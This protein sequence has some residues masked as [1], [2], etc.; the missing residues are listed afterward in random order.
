MVADKAT[1]SKPLPSRAAKSKHSLIRVGSSKTSPKFATPQKKRAKIVRFTTDDFTWQCWQCLSAFSN[2]V[3]LVEH[4]KS[5]DSR[6]AGEGEVILAIDDSLPGCPFCPR[7]GCQAESKPYYFQDFDTHVERHHADVKKLSCPYCTEKIASPR[8]QALTFHIL[9]DHQ[10]HWRPSPASMV[11][12]RID[13]VVHRVVTCLG[14]G[15]CT[16]VL[17][18]QDAVQPPASLASHMSRCAGRGGR[19]SVPRL[20]PTPRRSTKKFTRTFV[21]DLTTQSTLAGDAFAA[22]FPTV[23]GF[24]SPLTPSSTDTEA[25]TVKRLKYQSPLKKVSPPLP[26]PLSL[27]SP[28]SPVLPPE[29]KP[30]ENPPTE[31]EQSPKPESA[32]T[33]GNSLA[34][35]SEPPSTSLEPQAPQR[36]KPK[37]VSAARS[38][39]T[40]RNQFVPPGVFDV[41][42]DLPPS[43]P[44]PSSGSST[45][46]DRS[47]NKKAGVSRV[48]VCPICGDNALASLRER[49]KHLQSE[50]TGEL[51]FPCQLCGMAYPVY[52]ALRR[53]AV[54]KHNA[55]YDA[56]LYG[57]PDM[58]PVECPYCELVAFTSPEVLQLH[59]A[60]IHPEQFQQQTVVSAVASALAG[61]ESDDINDKDW[62]ESGKQ[63]SSAATAAATPAHSTATAGVSSSGD[64]LHSKGRRGRPRTRPYTPADLLDNPDLLE[65][66]ESSLQMRQAIAPG[67]RGR[68]R[69]RGRGGGGGGRGRRPRAASLLGAAVPSPPATV[70]SSQQ[71]A[72]ETS[73]ACAILTDADGHPIDDASVVSSSAALQAPPPNAVSALEAV[74]AQTLPDHAP[75]CCRLCGPE[76]QI[77]LDNAKELCIH[78]ELV[79]RLRCRLQEFRV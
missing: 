44:K 18:A 45:P 63:P 74:L 64:K 47:A 68:G 9:T 29:V 34:D 15:W 11:Y 69:G 31:S 73:D 78:M 43:P 6:N 24:A 37:S 49:D 33:N 8:L 25:V 2:N 54:L 36:K 71:P 20:P 48:Y 39:A 26:P 76:V 10:I 67:R 70:G 22:R 40:P 61:D 66:V 7:D 58:D 32:L 46:S 59:L 23:R 41:P 19:L 52:I 14:C 42:L 30:P 35:E 79:S 13:D 75:V 28:I 55:N 1:E 12:Q 3:D 65:R 62:T 72:E 51:V 21:N 60:K 38:S 5:C 16:F 57:Q 56:V 17:R 27:P 4:L 53:H 77:V 50:H